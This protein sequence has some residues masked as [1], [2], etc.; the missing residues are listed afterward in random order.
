[1]CRFRVVKGLLVPLAIVLLVCAGCAVYE[2]V[3]RKERP[4]WGSLHDLEANFAYSL[5]SFALS[6]LLIFKTNSSY[7]RCE[8]GLSGA[9]SMP[10]FWC[11][12]WSLGKSRSIN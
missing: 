9:T 12:C 5:C 1:M 4:S 11:I 2:E 6:L 7:G 8:S 3:V 10:G